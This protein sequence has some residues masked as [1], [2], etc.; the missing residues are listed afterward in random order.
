MGNEVYREIGFVMKQISK[1]RIAR[2]YSWPKEEVIF[3]F[4][5]DLF[6]KGITVFDRPISHNVAD[7]FKDKATYVNSFLVKKREGN[8]IDPYQMTLD[9]LYAN[10][11][12]IL[13]K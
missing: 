6:Q 1:G 7:H 8:I 2:R 4:G 9:D 12:I 11:W 5:V 3:D 13:K 10:D